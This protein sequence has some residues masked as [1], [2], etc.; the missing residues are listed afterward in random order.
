MTTLYKLLNQLVEQAILDESAVHVSAMARQGLALMVGGDN[1]L[2][3]YV[4]WDWE[5]YQDALKQNLTQ[6][7]IDPLKVIVGYI[8]IKNNPACDM[9][10]VETSAAQKGYGPGMYDIAMSDIFPDGL[11][12]DRGMTSDAARKVWNY[13]FTNRAHEIDRVPAEEVCQT[14]QSEPSDPLN[15]IYKMKSYTRQDLNPL[16]E[17]HLKA[18]QQLND[19]NLES[20]ISILASKFFSRKYVD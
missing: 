2:K 5:E 1:M 18:K 3:K 17:N 19:N 6:D 10:T 13:M 14:G 16:K 4:L 7:Q 9:W 12:S 15:F 8:K 11:T 20:N